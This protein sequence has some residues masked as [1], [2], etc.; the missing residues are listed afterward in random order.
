M[1][2]TPATQPG[3][4]AGIGGT[5][6][7]LAMNSLRGAGSAALKGAK[8]YV[9][10]AK[11][12][13]LTTGLITAGGAAAAYA[14]YKSLNPG[15]SVTSLTQMQQVQNQQVRGQGQDEAEPPSTPPQGGMPILNQAQREA[16]L[17]ANPNLTYQD[18][19]KER[20][21]LLKESDKLRDQQSFNQMYQNA[22]S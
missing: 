15:Y 1:A 8:G 2:D 14:G 10:L 12:A 20:F 22:L 3:R 4:V 18:Y 17:K 19:E 6:R 13:P 9:G 21:R 7:S 11:K 16:Q 5:A